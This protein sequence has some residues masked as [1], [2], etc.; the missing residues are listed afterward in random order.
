[1]VIFEGLM[2]LGLKSIQDNF[3]ENY[4]CFHHSPLKFFIWSSKL[5]IFILASLIIFFPRPNYEQILLCLKTKSHSIFN[6]IFWFVRNL[7]ASQA[8]HTHFPKLTL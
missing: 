2:P 4:G 8:N 3:I 7:F 5:M 1:M 6:V